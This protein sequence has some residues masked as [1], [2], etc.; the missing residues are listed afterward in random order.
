M[1]RNNADLHI[2]T[3][4]SDGIYTINEIIERA[5]HT[6]LAVIAITDHD[7]TN[8]LTQIRTNTSGLTIINGI[9]YSCEKNGRDV[10]ILGYNINPFDEEV[11]AFSKNLQQKRKMRCIAI[12][13]KLKEA[14]IKISLDQELN[15]PD[16]SLSRMHIARK[17]VK[18]G[19]V[20][21]ISDAFFTYI[22][23]NKQC[24][25][26]K[27]PLDVK[28]AC[29]FLRQKG[30]IPVL[31]HPALVGDKQTVNEILSNNVEGI[32]VYHPSHT[33]SQIRT[34]KQLAKEKNLLITG[35]SDFH[36]K[37][38]DLD[39]GVYKVHKSLALDLINSF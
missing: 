22:G 28:I 4:A 7:T 31:A 9:E 23:H 37:D 2:H 30:A 3:T 24:Y 21:S 26:E 25:V 17:M 34:F 27:E 32:E 15:D 18:K 19:Y 8:A 38:K 29:D 10:H 6:T 12:L 33:Q 20:S 35:G 13:E 11:D 1:N 16:I 39:L 5:K 14:G 36:G